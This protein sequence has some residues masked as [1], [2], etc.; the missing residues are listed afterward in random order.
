MF[1]KT[2]SLICF[3][4]PPSHVQH[5][6]AAAGPGGSHP[7]GAPSECPW[8]AALRLLGAGLRGADG[9]PGGAGNGAAD[10]PGA[11]GH[12]SWAPGA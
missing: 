11:A 6:R 8:G 10:A 7:A 12:G 3:K 5:R 9:G 4:L 2:S 1:L